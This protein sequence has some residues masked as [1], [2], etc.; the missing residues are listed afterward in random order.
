MKWKTK[1]Q[2]RKLEKTM[3]TKNQYKELVK[4]RKEAFDKYELINGYTEK[5]LAEELKKRGLEE[6][7][8]ITMGYGMYMKMQDYSDYLHE[9]DELNQEEIENK[10]DKEFLKDMFVYALQQTEYNYTESITDALSLIRL[11]EMELNDNELMKEAL[12]EA[13]KQVKG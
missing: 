10:K 1:K 8:V 4:K 2:K 11:T 12:E 6:K 13:K 3:Q 9:M 5:S 7:D